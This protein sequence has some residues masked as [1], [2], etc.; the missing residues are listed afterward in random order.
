MY[1]GAPPWPD[2]Y[3]FSLWLGNAMHGDRDASRSFAVWVRSGSGGSEGWWFLWPR[4]GVALKLRHGVAM[5]WDGVEQDHCSGLVSRLDLDDELLSVFVALPSDAMAIL[6]RREWLRTQLTLRTLP[7]V[8]QVCINIQD[9]VYIRRTVGRLPAACTSRSA[10]KKWDKVHWVVARGVVTH[11][12]VDG[13][14][15]RLVDH[16]GTAWDGDWQSVRNRVVKV[17]EW[18]SLKSK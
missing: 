17:L 7:G 15:V 4:H 14:C 6:R 12:S 10:I 3:N 8:P 13:I 9:K 18:I 16:H 5:S 11:V 1:P 2:W